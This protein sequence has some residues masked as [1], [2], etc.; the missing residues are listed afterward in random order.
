MPGIG[1]CFARCARQTRPGTV[2]IDKVLQ[3]WCK[4]L[5]LGAAGSPDVA[6][7]QGVSIGQ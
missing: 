6:M 5:L 3:V 7:E 4:I 2:S 1:C